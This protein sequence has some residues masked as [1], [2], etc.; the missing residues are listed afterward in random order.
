V[1]RPL[2]L[3]TAV[4][5]G[6]L[7]ATGPLWGDGLPDL[8]GVR[9]I[10]RALAAQSEELGVWDL[11]APSLAVHQLI[12]CEQDCTS[13]LD[14]LVEQWLFLSLSKE[15]LPALHRGQLV[16]T[17]ADAGVALD[18]TVVFADLDVSTVGELLELERSVFSMDADPPY[19]M[20]EPVSG[21]EMGWLLAA[22]CH[23]EGPAARIRPGLDVPGLI[24]RLLAAGI[25]RRLEGGS[26]ELEGLAHCLAA[27]E[28]AVAEGSAATGEAGEAEAATYARLARFLVDEVRSTLAS[29]TASGQLLA[30]SDG[31]IRCAEGG[32]TLCETLVD[33]AEQAHFFDWAVLVP[34]LAHTPG[35]EASTARLAELMRRV[36][37]TTSRRWIEAGWWN[38]YQYAGA[39]AHALRA[40][41]RLLVVTQGRGELPA[42]GRVDADDEREADDERYKGG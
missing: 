32:S 13:S 3:S 11:E 12:A 2:R 10:A 9:G 42:F 28:R 17:L 21:P 5:L 33:L 38:R 7:V 37:A 29:R 39:V 16:K 15:T 18:R 41:R 14:S 30:G 26:H 6:G 4:L 8:E 35:F 24:D 1:R 40:T 23:Y 31:W 22:L 19:G 20:S 36:E 27:H 34:G 25:N